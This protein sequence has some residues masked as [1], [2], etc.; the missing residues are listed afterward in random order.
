MPDLHELYA[1]SQ[2]YRIR[3]MSAYFSVSTA[4]VV[5]HR[6]IEM[7]RLQGKRTLITGGTSGIGLETA[8]QFLAEGARVIVTGVNPDSIAKARAELGPEVPV[9]RADSASVEAQKELA[10]VIKEHYG[11]LDVAFL[12]AGVSVWLPIEEWTE[13]MFDRSFDLSLIHI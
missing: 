5:I 6:R 7:S 10:Q 11:Q 1:N 3:R 8:K 13:D 12:N 2:S 9:L 4:V